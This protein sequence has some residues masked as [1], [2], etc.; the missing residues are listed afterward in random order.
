MT[1]ALPEAQYYP[2]LY[3]T[4][5][6]TGCTDANTGSGLKVAVMGGKGTS[7]EATVSTSTANIDNYHNITLKLE[8]DASGEDPDTGYYVVF[9]HY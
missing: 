1:G 3:V 9:T 8:T 7:R 5:T 2:D 4:F 6:L